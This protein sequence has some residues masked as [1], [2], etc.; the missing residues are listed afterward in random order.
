M[1][2]AS[3]GKLDLQRMW[4]V[5]VSFYSVTKFPTV[6]TAEFDSPPSISTMVHKPYRQRQT[7]LDMTFHAGS[8]AYLAG[9]I[10]GRDL[11]SWFFW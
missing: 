10:L 11:S 9:H 8:D 7:R 2:L 1:D 3:I 6:F 4:Y 5:D